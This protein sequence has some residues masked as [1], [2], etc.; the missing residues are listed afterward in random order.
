MRQDDSFE[1]E[2]FSGMMERKDDRKES[3]DIEAD[4]EPDKV[5]GTPKKSP[6]MR[7]R[8]AVLKKQASADSGDLDFL[9]PVSLI[10]YYH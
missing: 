6:I 9:A 1:N 10:A 4:R 3:S 7:R 2:G 8:M 5:D